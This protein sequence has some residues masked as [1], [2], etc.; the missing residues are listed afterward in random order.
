MSV[1]RE[2]HE[3]LGRPGLPV[4][5]DARALRRRRAD[6]LLQRPD[7]RARTRRRG[8]CGWRWRC[9]AGCADLAEGWTRRGHD[10]GF[11][12]GIAQ[13]YA[14]LGRIGFEGRYDYAA[15]GTV[16]NLGARLCA[17]AAGRGRSSSP[18]G[19]QTGSR[20]DRGHASRSGELTLR[21]FSRPVRGLRRPRPRRGPGRTHDQPSTPAR[22]DPGRAGRGGAQRGIRPA[23]GPAARG[24]DGPCG[25]TRPASPSWWCRRSR[26]TGSRPRRGA[27][28]QAMEE[29]FLFLLL[30]LRQPRLRMVYVTSSPIAPGDR[31]VLPRPAARASS[32]A[33]PGPGCRW[34]SVGDS[35][36]APAHREAAGAAPAARHI[37]RPHPRPHRSPPGALQHH[38]ARAGPRARAR[39]SPCTAPTRGS[40]ELGTEDRL[41]A[42]LRRGGRAPPARVRGPALARR[43]RRTPWPAAGRAARGRAGHRQA[44]RRRVRRRATP[45]ST[46]P[47]CRPPGSPTERGRA[48]SSGCGPCS[49]E[50]PDVPLDA[51]RREVRRA[52][53]HRRG[54][55]RRRRRCAVPSVQLRVTPLGEVEL[56]ST[57]D[58]LL[59]GPSGQCYL[60]CRFPADPAYARRDHAQRPRTIGAPAGAA[61]AC[62]A[63]SRSTS[64]W[65]ATRTA[66]GTSFAIEINLRKG[67]TTHPFLTLQFLTDGRY[68]ADDRPVPH[69]GRRARSTWSPPTTSRTRPARRCASTTCSTSS[70][71]RSALRPGPADRRGVPHDQLAHRGTAGSA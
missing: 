65:S 11:G 43:H 53:R 63:G 35:Y 56:L 6:G 27:V 60:G 70:P 51:L 15:I 12:V 19:S 44:Q 14:T 41:P 46:S 31:R 3:A 58:Q 22:A 28:N 33:M 9:A 36:A 39:A 29:R 34:S 49:F 13:G 67:G 32:P 30:L 38:P 17:E 26:W 68:D 16:T 37:A 48:A 5:G 21:G 40:F 61:R 66:A 42:A 4:R 52:R 64:S 47:A 18:S 62:S 45:S 7:A 55:D 57:H 54:A 50:G 24:L 71:A 23:A 25:S 1:L 8:R 10:L 20:G 69:P 2:Y 59:G